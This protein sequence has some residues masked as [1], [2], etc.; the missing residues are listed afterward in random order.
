[1]GARVHGPDCGAPAGTR[2]PKPGVPSRRDAGEGLTPPGAQ[3]H[4]HGAG[5]VSKNGV[6]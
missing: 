2:G 3:K 1:M 5:L 4:Q 6:G